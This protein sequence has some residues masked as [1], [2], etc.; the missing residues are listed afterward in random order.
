MEEAA[1]AE[2]VTEDAGQIKNKEKETIIMEKTKKIEGMMCGHCQARV[3]KYLEKLP[4]VEE[5]V[6]SWQQG[7]AIVK[8]NAEISDEVLKTTVEEQDYEVLSIE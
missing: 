3:K 2:Q 8:L 4:E 7:T 5:A 1:L 6:V